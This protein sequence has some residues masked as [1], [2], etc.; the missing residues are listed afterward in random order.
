MNS[1][2]VSGLDAS[3]R[4]ED[5]LEAESVEA[6]AFIGPNRQGP[7]AGCPFKGLAVRRSSLPFLPFGM[8]LVG[9]LRRLNTGEMRHC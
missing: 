3:E 7:R 6:G 1:G 4:R 9:A 5:R 8:E 2:E